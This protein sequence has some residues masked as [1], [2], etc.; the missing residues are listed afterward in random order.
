[1]RGESQGKRHMHR[2]AELLKF[3]EV[4]LKEA[5]PDIIR[6]APA[7]DFRR[8][9]ELVGDLALVAEVLK[10][11]GGPKTIYAGGQLTAHLTD[12]AHYGITLLLATGSKAHLAGLRDI[13]VKQK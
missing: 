9:C 5:T 4:H 11:Q 8:G 1:M 2:A 13:A 12:A 7:G 6:V 3:A 10:L